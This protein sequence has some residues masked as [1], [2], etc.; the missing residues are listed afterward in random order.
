MYA[1]LTA[2]NVVEVW[3]QL[4]FMPVLVRHCVLAC[5]FR[6]KGI[7]GDQSVPVYFND[8]VDH[9]CLGNQ[10]SWAHPIGT[11]GGCPV[12]RIQLSS[13]SISIFAN[14]PAWFEKREANRPIPQAL[15]GALFEVL[16]KVC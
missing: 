1:R 3:C 14:A 2:F 8:A 15:Q 10:A 13:C 11:N 5:S 16:R 4:A 7:V 6:R 12:A 9:S